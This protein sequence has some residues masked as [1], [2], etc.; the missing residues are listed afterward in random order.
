VP[1]VGLGV[2]TQYLSA[3]VALLIFAA[4]LLAALAGVARRL[5]SAAAA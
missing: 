3:G 5:L 1:V 4:V 2:A